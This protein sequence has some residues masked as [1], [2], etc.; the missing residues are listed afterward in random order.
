MILAFT[1]NR[2]LILVDFLFPGIFEQEEKLLLLIRKQAPVY[3]SW[4]VVYGLNQ[5]VK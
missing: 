1:K 5:S 4:F 2:E 3:C